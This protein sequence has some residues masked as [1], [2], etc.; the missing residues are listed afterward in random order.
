MLDNELDDSKHNDIYF[1]E[2]DRYV[3]QVHECFDR[4]GEYIYLI[5]DNKN[6]YESVKGFVMQ[7]S[8]Y[9]T[10]LQ[11][12]DEIPRKEAFEILFNEIDKDD[13]KI[14]SNDLKTNR[15]EIKGVVSNI[16][17]EFKKRD[18]GLAQFI[19]I[20]QEYE[21]NGKNKKNTISIMLENKTLTINKDLLQLNNDIY[22]VGRLNSYID[23]NN[24]IKAF[25]TC[26]ELKILNKEN[27][28]IIER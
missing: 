28:N 23:K 2:K 26:D 3:E 11:V 25:I 1:C 5:C 4:A 17:K 20:V 16:G 13:K 27:N 18:G 19:D 7:S 24:Q 12:V 15:I 6:Y 9:H 22:I 8:K 10:F 14:I 21:Y